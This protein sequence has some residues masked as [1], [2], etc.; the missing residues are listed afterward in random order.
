MLSDDAGID[1]A[2]VLMLTISFLSSISFSVALPSLWTYVKFLNGR[3]ALR[4]L[5]DLLLVV[6]FKHYSTVRLPPTSIIVISPF[7]YKLFTYSNQGSKSW[8]GQSHYTAQGLL[9][10]RHS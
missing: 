7:Q 2:I 3:M 1:G 4:C 8:V 10:L 5:S 6:T 9:S